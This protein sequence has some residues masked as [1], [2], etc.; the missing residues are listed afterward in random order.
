MFGLISSF[1]SNRR[2]RV[3]LDGKSSQEY[4]VNAGVP[5][6]SILG[7]TL[8][9]L[10]I[11]DLP[12]DV[13]CNIAIYADDTTLY[14]KCDQASDLWQQLELASELESDLRNTV[15]WGRKWLVDFNAGKT[16]LV[17]FDRSKNTGAIDV[18]MD[19]SVL[20][21]KTSFKMLGLTFCSK[22]DWGSYIVSIAKTTSKKIG[23]LIRSMKFLSPEIA[24]YLYKSTKRPCME[25]CCHVLPGASS[26]YYVGLL[27]HQLLPLLNPWLIVEMKQA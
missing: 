6:G 18:K 19:G 24:L 7:P 11:N 2:L 5:Q 10:Y 16:Q 1:L 9:L 4:P 20:E 15:D 25:Y 22:L 14:S 27:V 17:S 8:F 3:A 21:E 26:C 12:D 23:A 13:I